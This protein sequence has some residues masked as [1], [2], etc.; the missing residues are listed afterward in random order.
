M[1]EETHEQDPP[2][3]TPPS[4]DAAVEEDEWLAAAQLDVVQLDAV[5]ADADGLEGPVI[6]P[7]AQDRG[8]EAEQDDA[9]LS[10]TPSRAP[11]PP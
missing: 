3:D 2:A 6:G 1:A 9:H 8:E 11:A 5:G 10:Y 7:A 4:D